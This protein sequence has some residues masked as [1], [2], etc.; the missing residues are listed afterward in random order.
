[1]VSKNQTKVLTSLQQK[2]YR[3]K[4][5]LF[6]AEGLKVVKEL[7]NSSFEPEALYTTEPGIIENSLV[8]ETILTEAK[9]KQISALKTPSKVLAVF[10]I[11][12]FKNPETQG[13]TVALDGVRDP[14]N[15]GTIIR[16][17]DWYGVS[18]LICSPDTV[19]VYNPKVVQATMGSL[20]RVNVY[21]GVLED[22]FKKSGLPVY[23][24]VMQGTNVYDYTLPE[25]G[26]LLM[27]NE[28]NGISTGL[29]PHITHK[30]TIPRYGRLQQAES[31]NVA[32]ATGILLS[33]FRR[34]LTQK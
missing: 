20:A 22:Y 11:P 7:L 18:Q 27:G 32:T 21:Y 17:C 1:M 9:I 3:N 8:D 28:A 12:P 34:G 29:L 25:E 33:E 15:L 2:K 13:L 19:D 30:I 6:I 5:G 23:G 14:G 10:K 4:Y 24:A 31:L 26:I 16:L